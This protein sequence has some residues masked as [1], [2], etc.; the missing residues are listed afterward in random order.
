MDLLCE[1]AGSGMAAHEAIVKAIETVLREGPR[2]S[3]LRGATTTAES[4]QALQRRSE[5][6]GGC[7]AY[8][9]KQT[10]WGR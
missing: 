5:I 4:G 1:G 10:T 2:T 7:Y 6:S 9:M 8:R 3:D